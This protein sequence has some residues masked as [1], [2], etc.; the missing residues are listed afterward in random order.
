MKL[1]K[2][3]TGGEKK[4]VYAYTEKEEVTDAL[5]DM[6]NDGSETVEFTKTILMEYVDKGI[7]IIPKSSKP[8]LWD[9]NIHGE[10]FTDKK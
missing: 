1:I 5:L 3:F 7:C 4:G 2:I 9:E 10:F 6:M 8:F